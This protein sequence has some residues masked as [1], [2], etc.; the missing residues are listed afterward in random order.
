VI[1]KSFL[2]NIRLRVLPSLVVE[3]RVSKGTSLRDIFR[4][5]DE[6][7]AWIESAHTKMQTYVASLPRYSFTEDESF[8]YLGHEM[9]L[10]FWEEKHVDLEGRQLMCPKSIQGDEKKI[11]DELRK[12]FKKEAETILFL[13]AYKIAK[14]MG[15]EPK[16]IR[17]RDLKTRWGS[18]SHEGHVSL[19]WKLVACPLDVIDYVIVHE[20]CHLVHMNHSKDFWAMVETQCPNW[21]V[22]RRWLR[23]NAMKLDFLEKKSQLYS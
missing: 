13:R 16:K 14:D 1:R 5:F 21:K 2:R 17:L 23:K 19:S 20:Y 8:L 9:K 15:I 22:F 12:F 10:R 18:C 11:R 3:V 4:F 7:Q 6:N